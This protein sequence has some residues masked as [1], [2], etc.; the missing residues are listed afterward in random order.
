[1]PPPTPSIPANVTFVPPNVLATVGDTVTIEV[2]ISQATRVGSVPFHVAY[3]PKLLQFVL[4]TEGGFL[5][6]DGATSIFNAQASSLNE[7]F[8]ALAR[9][10]VPTG[11][12]SANEVPLCTLQFQAIAPGSTALRFTE[13]AVLDPQGQPLP[14][15][16]STGVQVQV[17]PKAQ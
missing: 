5:K 3:D 14:A 9:V 4:G 16:F 7:V 17:S 10:G 1:M 15:T 13:A 12:S 6:Q 11:A 2:H 8:V